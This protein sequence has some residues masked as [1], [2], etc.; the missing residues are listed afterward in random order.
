MTSYTVIDNGSGEAIATGLNLRDAAAEVLTSDSREYDIREDEDGGFALWSRQQV[1][2]KGWTRTVVY[3]IETDRE[4]AEA[5]IFGKVIVAD[6]PHHPSVMTD[7]AF[8]D[9]QRQLAEDG[10]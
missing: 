10:E 7:E 6:W 9:M 5:E 8:A 3:S 4:K 2:N 1:A